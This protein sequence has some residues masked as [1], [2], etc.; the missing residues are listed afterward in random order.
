M[1]INLPK[2]VGQ[3][4]VFSIVDGEKTLVG[5]AAVE[6]LSHRKAALHIR[7]S[8]GY[9]DVAFRS[10]TRITFEEFDLRKMVQASGLNWSDL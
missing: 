4:D 2:R 10:G 8:S 3:I 9:E 5:V 6:L 1:A 7:F